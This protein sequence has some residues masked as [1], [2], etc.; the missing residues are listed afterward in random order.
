MSWKIDIPQEVNKQEDIIDVIDS[1][2]ALWQACQKVKKY[3]PSVRSATVEQ[4][5]LDIRKDASISESLFDRK[6]EV[7]L[8][9]DQERRKKWH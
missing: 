4:Y 2:H 3:F 8:Q 6:I 1:I 5:W 9:Q 7:L